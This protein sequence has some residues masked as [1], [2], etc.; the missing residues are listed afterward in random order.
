MPYHSVNEIRLYYEDEDDGPLCLANYSLAMHRFNGHIMAME[1]AVCDKLVPFTKS[2]ANFGSNRHRAGEFSRRPQPWRVRRVF[3]H[4][5]PM[6]H[7]GQDA[8][9]RRRR[10]GGGV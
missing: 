9:G 4:Q 7:P 6:K 3:P 8:S 2:Y 1:R 5:K 10:D